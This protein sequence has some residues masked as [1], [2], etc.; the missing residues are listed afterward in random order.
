MVFVVRVRWASRC[1]DAG[2]PGSFGYR[3]DRGRSS[4][5]IQRGRTAQ[6]LFAKPTY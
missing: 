4:A 5:A 2:S 3:G 1:K 6:P